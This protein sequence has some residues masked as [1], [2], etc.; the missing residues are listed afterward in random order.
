MILDG[1]YSRRS[2]DLSTYS[3]ASK[4]TL[5]AFE[6]ACQ[7]GH[8]H[9]YEDIFTITPREMME[10]FCPDFVFEGDDGEGDGDLD[11]NEL[12]PYIKSEIEAFKAKVSQK[13]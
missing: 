11:P 1:Q 2:F 13:G 10:E 9:C 7:I 12:L 8:E 3:G 6:A 4:Y 5:D